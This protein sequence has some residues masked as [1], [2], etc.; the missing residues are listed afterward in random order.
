MATRL[1]RTAYHEAGHAVIAWQRKY[2]KKFK[3]VTILPDG[4]SLGHVLNEDYSKSDFQDVFDVTLTQRAK[5]SDDVVAVL[6]GGIAEKKFVGRADHRG[7]SQDYSLAIYLIDGF[8]PD[9]FWGKDGQRQKM[10]DYLF[11]V[12]REN[13]NISWPLIKA[14]AVVL[15]EKKTLLYRQFLKVVEGVENPVDEDWLNQ[16]LPE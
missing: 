2:A 4:D 8:E 9:G 6:A 5:M 3:Y 14:V 12:A 15:M 10:M 16:G 11:A 7:A 1:E 13:V